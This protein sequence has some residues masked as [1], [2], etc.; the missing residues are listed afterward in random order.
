MLAVSSVGVSA[1]G[2]FPLTVEKAIHLPPDTATVPTSGNNRPAETYSLG[3]IEP[4]ALLLKTSERPGASSPNVQTTAYPNLMNALSQVPVRM[5]LQVLLTVLVAEAD[6]ADRPQLEAKLRALLKLPD[7]V[8][9]E[10]LQHPE[11]A[12][13][14]AMLDAVFF[15]DTELWWVELQLARIDVVPMTTTTNRIDVSGKP[16]FVFDSTAA[17]HSVNNGGS[18]TSG[19]KSLQPQPKAPAEPESSSM[20]VA[21]TIPESDVGTFVAPA[22]SEQSSTFS[23]SAPE[24]NVMQAAPSPD[25]VAPPAPDPPA[26]PATNLE[27]SQMHVETA[28]TLTPDVFDTGNRFE[29]DSSESPMPTDNTAPPTG[30]EAPSP[31]PPPAPE[32]GTPAETT[33]GGN[34]SQ[35]APPAGDPST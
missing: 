9:V 29:P 30:T 10:V 19:L 3:R 13:F 22:A 4:V 14:N 1:C 33:P 24:F 7:E 34:E 8:L 6:P 25:P 26:P 28:Q 27:L 18:S 32:E 23:F 35:G 11:L 31:A 15:G 20:M 21:R 16:A 12:E 2:M 5:K 17:A